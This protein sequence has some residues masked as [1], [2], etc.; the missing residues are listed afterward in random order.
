MAECHLF[1]YILNLPVNWFHTIRL[2]KFIRLAEMPASEKSPVS[3]KGAWMWCFQDQMLRI[4]KHGCFHLGR[5]APEK[6]YDWT[7]LLVQD[8]D[9]GIGKLFPADPPVGIGLMGTDCQ[10]CV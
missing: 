3:R 2:Q 8:P 6:K 10:H 4:V 1:L 7:V 9:G 5:P